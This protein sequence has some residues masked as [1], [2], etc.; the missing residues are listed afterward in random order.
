MGLPMSGFGREFFKITSSSALSM[1]F[2]A[3]EKGVFGAFINVL[4]QF[5]ASY[6]I[7]QRMFSLQV[8]PYKVIQYRCKMDQNNAL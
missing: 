2:E 7:P 5:L 3:H 6:E 4:Y 1:Y 8:Q